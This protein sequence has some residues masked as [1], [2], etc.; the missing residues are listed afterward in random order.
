M[1]GI[2][3][4]AVIAAHV[5]SGVVLWS[6]IRRNSFTTWVEALGMGSALGTLLGL[7]FG[8][9]LGP[10]GSVVPAVGALALLFTTWRGITSLASIA[11]A[12]ERGWSL[13]WLPSAAAGLVLLV[14]SLLRTP[15]LNGYLVGDRYHGDLVFLEAV[16]QS[17]VAWGW[18]DNL[19]LAGEPLRYHWFIYAWS[20]IV[21]EVTGA[22]AFV[23]LTRATAVLLVLASAWISVAWA[24]RL[25]ATPIF[26]AA[27][28]L[29]VVAGGYVGAQQGTLLP[30]DSPSAG[31]G[32]VLILA[33]SLVISEYLRGRIGHAAL[34]AIGVMA[35]G[36]IGAKVTTAIV[37]AAGVGTIFIGSLVHPTS[38]NRRRSTW[39]LTVVGLS[40]LLTY[41]AVIAGV[42]G[43]DAQVKIGFSADHASTFQG[44]DPFQGV[45]GVLL[46]TTA[47]TLAVLPRWLGWFWL[48][49]DRT[50]RS[51][52][53]VW[54]TGG[55]GL[56]GLVTLYVL[57]SGTNAAWFA[58]AASAP[59]A[60]LSALGLQKALQ[61]RV[62]TAR[63]MTVLVVAVLGAIVISVVVYLNYGLQ[64]VT[65]APVGW[66]S[67]VAA[68]VTAGALAIL[69]AVIW[70]RK[71][72]LG[73]LALAGSIILVAA[74]GLA[75]VAGPVLWD[76]T[77]SLTSPFFRSIVQTVDPTAELS[78]ASTPARSSTS[79]P[80]RSTM[81][82]VPAENSLP[83]YSYVG[84]L[85]QWSPT[86]NEAAIAVAQASNSNDVLAVDTPYLQPYPSVVSG[87]RSLV[88]NTP[89]VAYYTTDEGVAAIEGRIQATAAFIANP[90]ENSARPLVDL[91][92]RWIWV[93]Q[94]AQGF[95]ERNADR[96][97]ILVENSEVV[98]VDLTGPGAN[99]S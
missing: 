12:G 97:E 72:E 83:G 25:G 22:E 63:P 47:L 86:L 34:V 66:R 62:P 95:A 32:T 65:G 40:S 73:T 16:G 96:F 3:I 68:W 4:T 67:S 13:A 44:L 23:V 58:L 61:S 93:Q 91:G 50:W 14:P 45:M 71:I 28:S 20:S 36:L 31:Y 64:A 2:A 1:T 89:L 33:A 59:I 46:G 37:L 42:A 94:N 82:R 92:V 74:S 70:W 75:R 52:P 79:M 57:S 39:V 84:S 7:G 9:F 19:L 30:F 85:V 43:G 15:I 90:T 38:I 60:V 8:L 21:T 49:R 76:A 35:A 41:L 80:G 11:P 99:F 81:T 87:V 26:A 29:L 51:S 27:A 77:S 54:M 17:V 5:F 18:Q 88:S 69:V 10:W 53:E 55:M 56:V 78:S 48:V 24:R 98:V 6:W